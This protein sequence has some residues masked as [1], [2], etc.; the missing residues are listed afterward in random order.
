MGFYELTYLILPDLSEEEVKKISKDVG[1]LIAQESGVL[2]KEAEPIKRKLGYPI[3]KK[4]EAFLVSLDFELTPDKL[5]KLEK[6]L[7]SENK[8]LRYLIF[9]KQSPEKI[10]KLFPR[11]PRKSLERMPFAEVPSEKEAA[12]TSFGLSETKKIELKEID[13]KIEEI[14]KE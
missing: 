13:K 14:L 12:K 5:E 2:K 7:K 4:A 1:E 8:I 10:K 9:A 6:K 11:E 3:N